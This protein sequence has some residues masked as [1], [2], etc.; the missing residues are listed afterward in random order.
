MAWLDK[1]KAQSTTLPTAEPT[2]FPTQQA[3]TKTEQTLDLVVSGKQSSYLRSIKKTLAWT[4]RCLPTYVPG[5]DSQ[6]ILAVDENG[7]QKDGGL[8][9]GT[10]GLTTVGG[11]PGSGKST[12]CYAITALNLDH[13]EHVQFH[14]FEKPPWAV[15]YHILRMIDGYH[16]KN[17]KIEKSNGEVLIPNLNLIDEYHTTNT[18]STIPMVTNEIIRW[19]KETNGHL[20][21]L[22]SLTD[23]TSGDALPERQLG[24][25]LRNFISGLAGNLS[26]KD[27]IAVLGTSQHRGSF[28]DTHFAGGPAVAHKS[29]AAISI[30]SG[31]VDQFN[32]RYYG[33]PKGVIA[34]CIRVIKTAD[35]PQSHFE[36]FFTIFPDGRCEVGEPIAATTASCSECGKYINMESDRYI[37]DPKKGIMHYNC[38]KS[39]GNGNGNGS[40]KSVKSKSE[41]SF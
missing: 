16:L 9:L 33:L 6:L 8:P 15:M 4:P 23:M 19:H 5:F 20:V 27:E 28:R 36:H 31:F 10:P 34:R 22:D 32:K 41:I 39:N 25:G 11:E 29:N 26:A 3:V 7:K 21:I 14:T 13:G 35:H 2:V 30:D 40:L 24:L 1:P 38:D 18:K 37:M 12:L 17:V